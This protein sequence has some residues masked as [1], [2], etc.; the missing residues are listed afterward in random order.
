[1][2]IEQTGWVLTCDGCGEVH[3][4][5]RLKGTLPILANDENWSLRADKGWQCFECRRRQLAACRL[6]GGG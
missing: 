3:L 1:M 4:V 5:A 2:A 6:A